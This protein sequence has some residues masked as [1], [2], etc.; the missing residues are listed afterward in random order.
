MTRKIKRF[1]SYSKV[2]LPLVLCFV[3]SIFLTISYRTEVESNY[4]TI[5][6]QKQYMLDILAMEVK[7]TSTAFSNSTKCSL[8]TN[9]I[10][11]EGIEHLDA[12]PH[13]LGAAYNSQ[14]MLIS[15]RQFEHGTPSDQQIYIDPT[16]DEKFNKQAL[17]TSQGVYNYEYEKGNTIKI[18]YKWVTPQCGDKT[19]LVTGITSHIVQSNAGFVTIMNTSIILTAMS[20]YVFIILWRPNRG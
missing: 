15:E 7:T 12:Q 17:K 6:R 8:I 14:L 19:L 20:G 9:S 2:V 10:M 11:K 13:T 3:A 5:L 18:H 4:D 16:Q 1:L